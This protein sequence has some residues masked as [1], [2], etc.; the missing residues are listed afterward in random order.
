MYKISIKFKCS[1]TLNNS[2][3]YIYQEVKGMYKLDEYKFLKPTNINDE[4]PH[5]TVLFPVYVDAVTW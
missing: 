3:D 5:F 1:K 4:C 2:A